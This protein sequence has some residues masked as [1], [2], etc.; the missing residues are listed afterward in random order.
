MIFDTFV[1]ARPHGTHGRCV[2]VLGTVTR[3]TVQ[4]D[5]TDRDA[6]WVVTHVDPRNRVLDG[7]SDT[8]TGRDTFEGR[9]VPAYLPQAMCQPSARR[10][11]MH[12]PPPG[13]TGRRCDLLPLW[14]LV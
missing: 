14:T 13:V 1:V 6:V 11:R 4:N 10:G 5:R 2:R 7:G 8:P 12:S 3:V 9:H